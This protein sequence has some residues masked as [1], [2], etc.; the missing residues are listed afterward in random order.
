MALG[1]ER[2]G[3][4][5]NDV[6]VATL[7]NCFVSD[8]KDEAR[9]KM[10]GPMATYAG[11]WP[12]YRRLMADAGYPDEIEEVRRAWQAGEHGRAMELVP[13]GL[14]DQIALTGTAEECQAQLAKYHQAGI[15]LP[16]VTPRVDGPNAKEDAMRVIRACAPSRG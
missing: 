6:D 2:A 9:N 3:R 5:P 8:D 11:F 15:K 4:D 13:S 1:A 14:I 16:I 12:R 10:R 7:V